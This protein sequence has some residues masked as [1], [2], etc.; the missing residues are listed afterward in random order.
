MLLLTGR[1][2]AIPISWEFIINNEQKVHLYQIQISNANTLLLS[3]PGTQ[4]T[5]AMHVAAACVRAKQ[6]Y[7]NGRSNWLDCWGSPCKMEANDA[8]SSEV[9][10]TRGPSCRVLGENCIC[11][12]A[13]A[14]LWKRCWEMRFHHLGVREDK[15]SM[16]QTAFGFP[17][18]F[19]L[20][21]GRRG[22]GCGQHV[23]ACPEDSLLRLR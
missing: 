1:K 22:R 20:C 17:A 19:E 13:A 16:L 18:A 3:L 12:I 15:A 7:G 6:M 4:T 8:V 2:L 11:A 10:R 14:L 9:R 21:R 5:P 23:L